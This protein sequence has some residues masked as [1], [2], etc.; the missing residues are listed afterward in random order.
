MLPEERR[1]QIAE[2]V[3][4]HSADPIQRQ[5]RD[6]IDQAKGVEAITKS[7]AA[8]PVTG[9]VVLEMSPEEAEQMRKEVPRATVLADRTLELIP[10]R[11]GAATATAKVTK[12]NLWHLKNIGVEAARKRG[13]GLSGKGVSIA[14]LDTGISP[15]PELNGRVTGAFTFNVT[16]WRPEPQDPSL[17]TQGHGT[18]VAGLI[19]GKTVGAAPDAKLLSGVMTPGGRGTTADFIL[20]LEW[21]AN[22]PEV[23]LVSMSAGIS[24][25]LPDLH[26]AL[27]YLLA[28]GVVAVVA[29]GNEG[30]N[31]TRSPGN[32]AEVL[33][34]GAT[35][36]GNGIP[37]FSS[38][39]TILADHHLYTV[40]NVVAPGKGVFSCV[41]E[42][43][44]EAWDGTSMSAPIVAGVAA[45]ILQRH[46]DIT[47][48]DLVDEVIGRCKVIEGERIRQ[49]YGLVRVGTSL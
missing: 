29:V 19:C 7:A 21:A 5:I 16:D 40:P 12:T 37:S 34:V 14:V 4:L 9:T 39:G 33:S 30:R 2:V 28:V 35:D 15:H 48:L 11:R 23:Q 49:G 43:G 47:V 22:Q 13:F 45:L 32:Y 41:R 17:D 20:A 1:K 18:H 25:Y 27:E 31:R 3:S 6:W 8:T 38:N 24:G 44:Y 42:G 26:Q 46:P 36:A 10:P